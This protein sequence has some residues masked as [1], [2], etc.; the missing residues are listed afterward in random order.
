MVLRI[1]ETGLRIRLARVR[2]IHQGQMEKPEAQENLEN[3]Q[4]NCMQVAEL[5]VR[6]RLRMAQPIPETAETV[7]STAPRR[8]PVEVVLW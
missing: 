1:R 6:H 5:V 7:L 8:E 4:E 2:E 3:R